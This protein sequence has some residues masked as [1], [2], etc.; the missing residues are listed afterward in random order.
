MNKEITLAKAAFWSLI[1]G[2]AIITNPNTEAAHAAGMAVTAPKQPCIVRISDFKLD[3]TGMSYPMAILKMALGKTEKEY[4]PCQIEMRPTGSH[5][6]LL[7]QV[8]DGNI[9][10][11]W[12]VSTAER[13][14]SLQPIFI[15]IFQGLHGYKVMIIRKGEEEK[16]ANIRDLEGL[17]KLTAGQAVDWQ[18]TDILKA[19]QL[20]VDTSGSY[21]QLFTMLAAKRFDYFP[22]AFHEPV[23]ELEQKSN[24]SLTIEPHLLLHYVAPDYFFVSRTNKA[25]AERIRLGFLRGIA[26]GTRDRIR[27]S[28]LKLSDLIRTIQPSKR[29]VIELENPTLLKSIPIK[30]KDY[31]IDL[32]TAPN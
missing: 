24:L 30:Q 20:P 19:N 17:R 18:S 8:A 12:F 25:L 21:D 31:W 7:K 5:S 13:E 28:I 6:R 26:D 2:I 32:Q 29:Y 3:N 16:F 22:R 10:V 27:E 11:A 23:N 9:D 14:N 4:G 1:C 15:P